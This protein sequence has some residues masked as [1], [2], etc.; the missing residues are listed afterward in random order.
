[1][2]E[3]KEQSKVSRHNNFCVRCARVGFRRRRR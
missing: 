3:L 2:R 1:M